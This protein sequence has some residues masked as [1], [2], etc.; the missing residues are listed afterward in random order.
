MLFSLCT[1]QL[2]PFFFHF[3]V[4]AAVIIIAFYGDYRIGATKNPTW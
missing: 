4:A 2:V 3:Y 1:A